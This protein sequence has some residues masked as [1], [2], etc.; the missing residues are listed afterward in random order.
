LTRQQSGNMDLYSL[1]G[2]FLYFKNDVGESTKWNMH[3]PPRS[4]NL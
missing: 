2:F 4:L 1:L 3:L